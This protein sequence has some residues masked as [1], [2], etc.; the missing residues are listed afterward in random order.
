MWIVIAVE[1]C[2]GYRVLIDTWWNVNFPEALEPFSVLSVLIDT[3]WNVNR[4]RIG[5][6][7]VEG[8]VLIDTWWNVND[9]ET[10]DDSW[11][12][13]VLIDTW[14]N[15]NC[16]VNYRL[17]FCDSCFNR[18]MVECEFKRVFTKANRWN[19]FNRYMV[20]CESILTAQQLS[21]ILCFNR[22][23]VE[24]ECRRLSYVDLNWHVLID[25]WWNVNMTILVV[26]ASASGF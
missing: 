8:E 26:P 11:T 10:E 13:P 3:W 6:L 14:W 2:T 20:E 23:M 9:F 4:K 5:F 22:Y 12:N 1:P 15:V 19:G 16:S 7:Y 21:E 18:Y 25:T 24:C 17:V